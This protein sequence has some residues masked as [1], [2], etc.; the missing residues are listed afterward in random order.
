M[1]RLP[2]IAICAT[3]AVLL[4]TS[5]TFA[6]SSHGI[7]GYTKR[8]GTY[9]APSRATNPDRFKFNNYSTKGNM[10]PYTGKLGTKDPYKK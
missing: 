9:V 7:K 10:N 6:R 4:P 5:E 2:I 1:K 8:S 3:L